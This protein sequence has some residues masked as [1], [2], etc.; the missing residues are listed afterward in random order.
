[1]RAIKFIEDC[2]LQKLWAFK[3][4]KEE[5]KI[6]HSRLIRITESIKNSVHSNHLLWDLNDEDYQ[7]DLQRESLISEESSQD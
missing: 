6:L 2:H 4:I 3:A 5:I 7:G 1:M